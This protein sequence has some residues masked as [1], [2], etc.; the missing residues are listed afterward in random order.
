M[1][2]VWTV[3]SCVFLFAGIIGC[4]VPLLPGPPLTFIG[5]LLIQ[6]KEEPP[7]STTFLW[8][9]AAVVVGVSVLD[10]VVPIYGTRKFGGSK[11]GM[12]GCSIGLLAGLWLGPLGIIAGPFIGAF[13]GE[14]MASQ[15]SEHAFKAAVGSFVGFLLGTL[16]KLIACFVMTWY[17]FVALVG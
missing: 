13:I 11:Y 1:D 6:L 9:C 4:V 8:I 15:K 2:V 3:V 12:W 16:L 17:F 7:F 14:M 10:Y 5:L